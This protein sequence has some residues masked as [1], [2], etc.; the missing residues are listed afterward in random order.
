[1]HMILRFSTSKFDVT[2][3]RENPINRIPGESLLLWLR[4]Q[5]RQQLNVPAPEPEDW[6]W[7]S[8][9]D[10]RGRSYMLGSSASE[11]ENG[12]REWVLQ[13]VKHRSFAE[14]VF[15]REKPSSEDECVQFF[16]QALDREPTFKRVSLES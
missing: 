12:E 5:V 1:M 6:G 9:I 8:Y 2:K 11:E 14:K 13:V 3:E 7:C 15:G 16:K 4:E 10:W